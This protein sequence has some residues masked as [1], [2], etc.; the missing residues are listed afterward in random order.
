MSSVIPYSLELWSLR[1]LAPG[2][3]AV[4]TCLSPVIAVIAGWVVLGQQLRW[5]HCLAIG[6]VTLASVGAVRSARGSDRLPPV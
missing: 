4:L 3:F 2:T 1:T 5:T 6:L